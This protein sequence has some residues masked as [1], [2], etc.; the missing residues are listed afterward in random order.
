MKRFIIQIIVYLLIPFAGLMGISEYCM[1][2]VPNDYK[3]KND[4][5]CSNAKKVEIYVL[6]SSHTYYG[7]EPSRF[8]LSAFNGAHVSQGLKY[9]LFLLQKFEQS[10]DSLR[11]VILPISYFTLTS[12][13]LE[14]GQ[15]KWRIK[16]YTIYYDCPY[17]KFEP[18]F[19]LESYKFCPKAFWSAI[20]SNN[21]HLSCNELGRGLNYAREN[22]DEEGW[23]DSGVTAA[24][25]H[26]VGEIKEN[27][28]RKN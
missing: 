24:K 25:R 8:R 14:N 19:A 22:R 2:Q 9:D 21:S 28:V 11:W 10:M 27:I 5:L 4:W 1:R 18:E 20:T 15:E 26:T 12:K 17:H 7:I 13:G 23:K 6:G 16:N 3:Y